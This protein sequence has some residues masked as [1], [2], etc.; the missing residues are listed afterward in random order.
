MKRTNGSVYFADGAIIELAAGKKPSGPK[1]KSLP[2][3]VKRYITKWRSLLGLGAWDISFTLVPL[4]NEQPNAFAS[5]TYDQRRRDAVIELREDLEEL[6]GQAIDWYGR[7]DVE[8]IVVH[9]LLH[10]V[11]G[12]SGCK[13]LRDVVYDLLDGREIG[14]LETANEAYVHRLS[15]ILIQLERNSNGQVDLRK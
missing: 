11:E 1:S 14:N 12:D 6:E 8:E 3:R 9:E 7:P 15:R 10:I 13:P 5:V 4:P 2:Q